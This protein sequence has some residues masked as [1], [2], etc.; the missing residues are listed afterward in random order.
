MGGARRP[1]FAPVGHVDQRAH[2]ADA[3]V[4]A[5][6]FAVWIIG[7]AAWLALPVSRRKQAGAIPAT[8]GRQKPQGRDKSDLSGSLGRPPHGDCRHELV[9]RTAADAQM[10][11]SRIASGRLPG[12]ASETTQGRS[13]RV[14]KD[15]L[16]A[17]CRRDFPLLR[18]PCDE[19]AAQ[20]ARV[21]VARVVEDAGLAGRDAGFRLPRTRPR[22]LAGSA[23]GS[24]GR[25]ER[26]RAAIARPSAGISASSPSPIQL[27]SRRRMRWVSSAWARADDHP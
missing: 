21:G 12:G 24:G 18:R 6:A 5:G 14:G 23:P 19:A 4:H 1:G 11:A 17:E 13:G 26:T 15:P 27:T 7:A 20:H 22:R 3:V 10:T 9:P 8:P 2:V 16:S 25:V